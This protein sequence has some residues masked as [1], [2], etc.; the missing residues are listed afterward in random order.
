[1]SHDNDQLEKEEC[2]IVEDE[3]EHSRLYAVAD[4]V[5]ADLYWYAD[6]CNQ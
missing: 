6:F 3:Q 4:S 1:M 5:N 2:T